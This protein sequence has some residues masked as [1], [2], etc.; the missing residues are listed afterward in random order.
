MIQLASNEYMLTC[1]TINSGE[2][3]MTERLAV[4]SKKSIRKY[5]FSSKLLFGQQAI[6]KTK[7][8]TA[9]SNKQ[10]GIFPVFSQNF[11]YRRK[12]KLVCETIKK[13]LLSSTIYSCFLLPFSF[14]FFPFFHLWSPFSTMILCTMNES[15]Q[16]R[17]L[18]S[19]YHLQQ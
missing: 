14:F 12:Q 18:Y 16:V 19:M 1:C 5:L 8:S 7:V 11:R 17:Y 6:I 4:W 13:Y 10:T 9:S 15:D 3:K 2:N